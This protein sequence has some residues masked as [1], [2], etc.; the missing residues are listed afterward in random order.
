MLRG[1]RASLLLAS[2]AVVGLAL[3]AGA[4][5]EPTGSRM[6]VTADR[7]V[8]SLTPPQ[9]AK[10]T[11]PYDSP[12][13]LNWHFIPRGRKGLP[14]KE[15]SPEQRALA[16]ALIQ[17]GL[18][19][20]GFLKATTIMSLEQILRELEK[21]SGPVRDP[22]LYYLTIF[23]KPEDRGKW[24][25][26][27]EGHH[28]SLNFT[29]EDGKI[30]A[31]TPAFFGSNPGEVRQGPRQGLQTLADRDERALR[32]VQALDDEQRKKAVFAEKAP[33]EIRAAATP[34]P[35]TDAAVGIAYG[36]MN[37]DQRASLRALIE[38]YAMDMPLEVAKAWLDEIASAGSENVKF[39]WAGPADRSQGH[40]YRIQGPTFLI[41]FNNT[42]NNANHVHSVWRNMLGDFGISLK[43]K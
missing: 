15:L 35:P 22:E 17:S 42:Q 33:G 41:E 6:A 13:R 28:L 31:A 39:T 8:E 14:I 2:V 11:Y 23:G 34:Q 16:F 9:V 26:R 25:W 19:G 4:Q 30:T 3:W 37:A 21:G 1:I 24:G 10:A 32:L 36:E 12:E 40:A 27:I 38:S 5:V 20:S 18:S 29:L 7:L 43:S